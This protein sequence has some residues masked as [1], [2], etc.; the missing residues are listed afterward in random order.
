MSSI[1]GTTIAYPAWSG[2]AGPR[3]FGLVITCMLLWGSASLAA[4]G[5]WTLES[6]LQLQSASDPQI[7]PDG[8][9]VA[10]VV[11]RMNLES[12]RRDSEIRIVPVGGG[13]SRGLKAAHVSDARPRWS[14]AGT[15]IAFL[16]SRSGLPQVFVVGDV[17][18]EPRQL[19]HAERGVLDFKWSPDG[20]RMAFLS[21]DPPTPKEL[22]RVKRG[23]DP[24]VA[25]QD[26]KFSRV[27]RVSLNGGDAAPVTDS[28]HHVTGFDWSPD[29]TR[30]VYAAQKT[31]RPQD[32]FH[33]DLFELDLKSGKHTSLVA[34]EGREGDPS[35]SPDG[36][37]IAFHS[38]AGKINYFEERHVGVIPSGGGDIRWIT[39]D[40]EVD[41]FRGGNEF[42]WSPDAS[43]LIFGGGWGTRDSLYRSQWT[44]RRTE[45]LPLSLSG[46]SS[47]SL[48]RKGN[49][50]AYLKSFTDR[51]AEVY[52]ADVGEKVTGER[53]L[54]DL[55]PE[56]RSLPRIESKTVSWT[57]KDGTRIEGVLRLPVGYRPGVRVPL[58]VEL[59]G[60]PTGVAL[61]TFPVPRTYP[62][63]LFAQE[64]FAVLAPNFRGSS[65]YGRALRLAN[66]RSQ[67]F[68][69]FDD[70]MTG[71]DSLINQG[72]ADPQRLGVYGWSYGG[73]LTAWI[74]G[75]TDRFKAASIGAPAS[76]WIA[77]YGAS[78]GPREV[79]WTYFG[80][81]PWDTWESY[82]RHSP[83]YSLINAKTPTLI[84]HGEKDIDTA[85]EIFRALEDL[86]VPNE[87]VTYPREGHGITEPMHQKDLLSR[88]L[89]WF[90]K[91]VLKPN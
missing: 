24:I 33:C 32:V 14:P 82:N 25:N 5:S 79:M 54:T 78:D 86:G 60:G 15:Q 43:T 8:S 22:E 35:Y 44:Q 87:F 36:Q 63:Q 28:G 52:V 37:W 59:H 89:S 74:I 12:N 18:L 16:S 13:S 10:F 41:V 19:T 21:V 72:I 26:Y 62:I 75:H 83:R 69:D 90:K 55:N 76:D 40:V 46:P 2:G 47:F 49:R 84:L 23:D 17:N 11:T 30:L 4:S 48:S 1:P 6:L 80:G 85:P 34:L 29:G 71:I 68:G 51:T 31:P 61:E 81:K 57:S 27:Y 67:G 88:N 3:R 42:W 73:F 58:L 65:N 39:K 45:R 66:I 77:W 64:G 70:V 91:W 50:L 7:S 9:Q 53:A 38:Q 56:I 20:R